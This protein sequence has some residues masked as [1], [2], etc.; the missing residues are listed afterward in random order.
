MRGIAV[1]IAVGVCALTAV[2]Q[3]SKAPAAKSPA[4]QLTLGK[5]IQ[6]GALALVPIE[7]KAP[8]SR[9][10][11]TVLADATRFGWVHITE[12]PEGQEVNALEVKNTG[13]LPLMLFAGELLLGGKQDRIVGRDTIVPP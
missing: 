10:E 9:D 3:T 11:Y 2:S 5:P 12:V 4:P 8:L 7:A 1:A 6:I 13:K